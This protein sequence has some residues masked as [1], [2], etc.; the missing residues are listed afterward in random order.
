MEVLKQKTPEIEILYIQTGQG[1]RD[2]IQQSSFTAKKSK[3]L[4]DAGK[5]QP[6]FLAAHM[7]MRPLIEGYKGNQHIIFDGTPR[8]CHEAGVLDSC[9]DFY[10]FGKPWIVN[11]DI[12]EAEAIR[13]MLERKRFDDKEEDA[14][15]R[16]AWYE[17]DVVPTLSYY[18]ANP[19]YN[20][21]KIFG[22]RSIEDVHAD[23]VKRL[24]LV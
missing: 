16:L 4:Y 18:D 14:R 13:R 2:F 5:L 19:R 22:E 6:E 11:I 20:F 12:S 1:F 17:T 24:G 7:W 23:I 9:F 15:K 21:L 10:G 3:E 8:K